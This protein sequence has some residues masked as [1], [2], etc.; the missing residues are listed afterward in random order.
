[1]FH[2]FLTVVDFDHNVLLDFLVNNETDFLLYLLQYVF[3]DA[4]LACG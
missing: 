2:E 1:M 3:C 4:S